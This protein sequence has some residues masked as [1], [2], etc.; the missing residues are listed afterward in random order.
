MDTNCGTSAAGNGQITRH[1]GNLTDGGSHL[2]ARY[3]LA[4]LSFV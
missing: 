1:A 2:V 3:H 4:V